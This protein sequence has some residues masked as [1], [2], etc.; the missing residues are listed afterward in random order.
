MASNQ[1]F[2]SFKTNVFLTR[3]LLLI[4]KKKSFMN[5]KITFKVKG[6]D[7]LGPGRELKFLQMLDLEFRETSQILS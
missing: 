4:R 1:Y 7:H 6:P 5:E 2:S 3:K